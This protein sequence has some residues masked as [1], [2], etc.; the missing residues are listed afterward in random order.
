M[1]D[2]SRRQRLM[3]DALRR[4]VPLAD[5][6]PSLSLSCVSLFCLCLSLPLSLL[7]LSPSRWLMYDALRRKVPIADL[8]SSGGVLSDRRVT[9]LMNL[10]MQLR[11]VRRLPPGMPPH[12]PA[13]TLRGSRWKLAPVRIRSAVQRGW[14]SCESQR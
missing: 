4:K 3:Y 2:L 6:M 10:V 5:L 8:M 14:R 7:S 1:C 13:G 11:K 12:P 9:S